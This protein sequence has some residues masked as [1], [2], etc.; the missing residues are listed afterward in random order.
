[1]GR[2]VFI[3]GLLA[4][5]L[6]SVS[7]WTEHAC[8]RVAFS[9]CCFSNTCNQPADACGDCVASAGDVDRCVDCA[10]L[11]RHAV[12]WKTCA[13]KEECLA[14]AHNA[15]MEMDSR[16][17]RTELLSTKPDFGPLRT[18]AVQACGKLQRRSACC[19]QVLARSTEQT[20][21]PSRSCLRS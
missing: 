1:M 16:D 17:R 3:F 21:H 13:V 7:S 15:N 2:T 11:C 4:Y 20:G 18:N 5:R 9:T 12:C 8:M 6:G 10:V 19:T 14:L